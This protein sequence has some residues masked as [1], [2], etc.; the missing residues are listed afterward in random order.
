MAFKI[1]LFKKLLIVVCRFLFHTALVF[2]CTVPLNINYGICPVYAPVLQTLYIPQTISFNWHC[3]KILL[4]AA[5]ALH[6]AM[7]RG[8]GGGGCVS[9]GDTGRY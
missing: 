2:I 8:G 3:N 9:K 5:S 7:G 1:G 6:V 4:K